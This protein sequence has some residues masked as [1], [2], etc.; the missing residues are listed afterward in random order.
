VSLPAQADLD[1][2][3]AKLFMLSE[4]VD[5]VHRVTDR[6]GILRLRAVEPEEAQRRDAG[7]LEDYVTKLGELAEELERARKWVRLEL[8]QLSD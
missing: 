2:V 8:K 6:A 3:E 5:G 1:I 7:L 4:A